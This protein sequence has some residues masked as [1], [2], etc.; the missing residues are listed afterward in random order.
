VGV[1]QDKAWTVL[2]I[3][4]YRLLDARQH[5]AIPVRKAADFADKY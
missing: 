2:V 5:D 4:L 1:K 3:T